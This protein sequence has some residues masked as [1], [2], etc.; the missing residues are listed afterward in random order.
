MIGVF[1]FCFL[2]SLLFDDISSVSTTPEECRIEEERKGQSEPM[3][4]LYVTSLVKT[5]R[6]R[7]YPNME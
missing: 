6:A 2:L 3:I 4:L 5:F 1:N 7:Q